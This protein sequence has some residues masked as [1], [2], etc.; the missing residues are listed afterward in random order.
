M[1]WGCFASRWTVGYGLGAFA[2]VTVLGCGSGTP[3]SAQATAGPTASAVAALPPSSAPASS[4]SPSSHPTDDEPPHKPRASVA[5]HWLTE[6]VTRTKFGKA[7][8]DGPMYVSIVATGDVK[9]SERL[10]DGAGECSTHATFGLASVCEDPTA[11]AL[12]QIVCGGEHIDHVLCYD[13]V[14]TDEGFQVTRRLYN[15]LGGKPKLEKSGAVKEIKVPPT[16]HVS[17]SAAD[18]Q[19]D[20]SE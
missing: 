20:I 18:E 11:Q 12:T 15:I 8:K 9:A 1:P 6:H 4:A 13:A 10:G 3:D 19:K 16:A 14:R 17:Y 5:I 7:V 2:L